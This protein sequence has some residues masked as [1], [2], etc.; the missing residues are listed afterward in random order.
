MPSLSEAQAVQ[1][2]QEAVLDRL[3]EE[4]RRIERRPARRAGAVPCG[5]EAVDAALGG[6]FRRGALTELSGGPASGKTA[7]ALALLAALGP[8][9]LAAWVDAGWADGRGGLYPPAAAALGVDLGRLLLVRPGAGA[10][11]RRGAPGGGGPMQPGREAP[12]VV[13]LWAGEAL[14]ASGAFAAVVLDVPV[15][16]AHVRGADSMVRRLQ[17]AV[18]KGGTIGIWL[19][20]TRASGAL[21]VPAA[22]R[23]ELEAAPEAPASRASSRPVAPKPTGR[24]HRVA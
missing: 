19:S 15:P 20:R 5:V 2:S 12:W 21:R 17:A 8:R 24:I 11:A 9:D 7:A 22:A 6:G 10:S 4:I 16:A 18:E 1:S 23:V 3:R 13:A 14:L